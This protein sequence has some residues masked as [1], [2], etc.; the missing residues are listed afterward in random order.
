M[1]YTLGNYNHY[2]SFPICAC[3]GNC[4]SSSRYTSLTPAVLAGVGAFCDLCRAASE[5]VAAAGGHRFRVL[6]RLD[7]NA[8]ATEVAWLATFRIR[9]RAP[10]SSRWERA[11]AADFQV[12]TNAVGRETRSEQRDAD[13]PEETRSC[14]Q[15]AESNKLIQ[16]VSM[17]AVIDVVSHSPFDCL[18]IL[19]FAQSSSEHGH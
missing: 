12:P 13:R 2:G 8:P 5:R 19:T 14:L 9:R 16:V 1:I 17:R 18:R 10:S 15:T 7:S 11:R 3:S 6:W 4:P